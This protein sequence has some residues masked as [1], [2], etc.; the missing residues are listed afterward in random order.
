[1]LIITISIFSLHA[2]VREV[3]L[4]GTGALV[5]MILTAFIV[6]LEH[7]PWSLGFAG[8]AERPG[9]GVDHPPVARTASRGGKPNAESEA[10]LIHPS[11]LS[12]VS[13]NRRTHPE[14]R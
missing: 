11:T 14:V 6:R 1:M 3:P 9:S 7:G 10:V 8:V 13:D 4:G 5:L 2:M 12:A